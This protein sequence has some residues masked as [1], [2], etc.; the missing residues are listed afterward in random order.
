MK[1]KLA[2]WIA[3]QKQGVH[4]L[5]VGISGAQG[6]GKSTLAH[7]LQDILS[8]KYAVACLSMDDLYLNQDKR[9]GLAQNIHPLLQTRG[10]PT[11][12]DV[13]LGIQILNQLQHV[14]GE[15]RLP[16]FDKQT[17]NPKPKTEW[18][19][20][21]T[22]VD[23][24]LFEGWCLGVQAQEDTDLAAPMNILEAEEDKDGVWRKQANAALKG[25]YQTLFAM[26]DRLVYLQPPSFETVFDWRKNQ[27]S[28][29][30]TN[31]PEQGMN[32]AELTRFMAHFER[33]TE[34]GLAT[35]PK[36][37]DVVIRLGEQHQCLNIVYRD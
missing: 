26:V 13:G 31:H 33:L 8:E 23:I 20:C 1:R 37:A 11:T 14:K 35:L 2:N 12:H 6:T 19:V 16:S 22:P 21:Q 25:E 34:H 17:D 24:V 9:R 27:E 4:T 36:Q 18:E 28:E 30:F 32:D 5:V 3:A 10:V 15:V 7:Q 29:T